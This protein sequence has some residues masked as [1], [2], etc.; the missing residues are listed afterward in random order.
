MAFI[1][2][3]LYPASIHFH[4]QTCQGESMKHLARCEPKKS[5]ANQYGT[6]LV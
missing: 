4:L 1:R 6:L 5:E 2:S 3:L